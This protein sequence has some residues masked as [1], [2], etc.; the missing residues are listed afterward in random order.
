MKVPKE[1]LDIGMQLKSSEADFN[2]PW[3]SSSA[4]KPLDYHNLESVTID[5]LLQI[6]MNPEEVGHVQLGI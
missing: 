4:I 2:K 5:F 1:E 6:V 3:L